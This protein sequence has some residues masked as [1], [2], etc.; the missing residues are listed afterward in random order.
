MSSAALRRAPRSVEEVLIALPPAE[1]TRLRQ[2]N[3]T[4]LASARAE[5]VRL[6]VEKQ[7]LEEAVRRG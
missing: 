4:Q 2:I 3:A 6:E 5:V 7:Q 1:L